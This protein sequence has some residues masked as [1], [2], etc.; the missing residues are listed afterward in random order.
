MTSSRDQRAKPAPAGH[1]RSLA[2]VLRDAARELHAQPAP[3][4]SS[5][6]LAALPS[7]GVSSPVKPAVRAP[8]VAPRASRWLAFPA[9]GTAAVAFGLL[10]V[11]STALLLMASPE[12]RDGLRG[13]MQAGAGFV[14][15][16][17][18]ERWLRLREEGGAAWV[19]NTEM[20]QQRLATYGLPYDP[21][22]A[23]DP[24]RAEL[25]MRASGEVLA[26]RVLHG[27][28]LADASLP[29]R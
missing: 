20:P 16:V 12:G 27:P 19:V 8:G 26:V 21:M 14:P 7:S 4:M 17:S 10:L 25:L 11:A 13:D 15:V 29:A 6:V 24:V 1:V 3:A 23:A 2:D 9:L 5:R 28:L 18:Q 22:R